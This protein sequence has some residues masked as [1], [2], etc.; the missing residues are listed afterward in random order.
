MLVNALEIL[1]HERP[2]S[3]CATGLSSKQTP[4]NNDH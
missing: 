2:G 1:E 3:V 4:R